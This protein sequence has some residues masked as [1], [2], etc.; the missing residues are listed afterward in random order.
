MISDESSN[1]WKQGSGSI[2]FNLKYFVVKSKYAKDFI[3][4]TRVR[5]VDTNYTKVNNLV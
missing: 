2:K 1:L 3:F 4:P 5:F